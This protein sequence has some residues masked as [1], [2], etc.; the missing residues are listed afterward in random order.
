MLVR[1]LHSFDALISTIGL[2]NM[3]DQALKRDGC[4][5]V[6][7]GALDPAFATGTVAANTRLAATEATPII[8]PSI[9]IR[10]L[11]RY[12]GFS[13]ND[14]LCDPAASFYRLE[15]VL[16]LDGDAS[17]E[18]RSLNV[19]LEETVRLGITVTCLILCFV[20]CAFPCYFFYDAQCIG[21]QG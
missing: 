12:A 19:W 10:T 2:T 18:F 20:F 9:D 7:T 15:N 4:R 5:C 1:P 11:S 6:I 13:T 14:P 3:P 21:S 17:G 8:P 16:T